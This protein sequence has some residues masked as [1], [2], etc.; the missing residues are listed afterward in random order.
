M[1]GLSVYLLWI[2]LMETSNLVGLLALGEF[3][4][5]PVEENMR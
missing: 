2:H 1:S 5:P 4:D 3:V